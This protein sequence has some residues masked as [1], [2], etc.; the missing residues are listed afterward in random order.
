V[1]VSADGPRGD[2]LLPSW[3]FFHIHAMSSWSRAML[4]PL[5][6]LNHY[7]PTRQLPADKQL[8]EL[9][10]SR[11]G[12]GRVGDRLAQAA[13]ELVELLPGLRQHP[14]A[15]PQAAMEALAAGRYSPCEQWI[16]EHMGEESD[17]LAAIFPAMLN[18]MIALKALGYSN[19]HPVLAKAQRDFEGL[20]VDDP[21][22]FRI[23]PCLSRCGTPR[24][25]W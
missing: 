4:M 8:H 16:V 19:D 11:H 10:P 5:A 7:K 25:I 21:Q 13:L 18:A 17:G 15:P 24:S 3:S 22:D 14:E 1:E 23:Q 20:F 12:A 6:I 9:Y 2:D